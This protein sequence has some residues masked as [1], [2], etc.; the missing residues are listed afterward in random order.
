MCG[1]LAAERVNGEEKMKLRDTHQAAWPY[2][3]KVDH[4]GY[5]Y[6]NVGFHELK[7]GLPNAI[8]RRGQNRTADVP[9]TTSNHKAMRLKYVLGAM[10]NNFAPDHIPN[11]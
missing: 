4:D 3:E 2:I 9:V 1:Q 10:A 5:Y 8:N 6:A 11:T 7:N